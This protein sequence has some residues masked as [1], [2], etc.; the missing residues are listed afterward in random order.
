MY[1]VICAKY[2]DYNDCTA[3]IVQYMYP[4]AIK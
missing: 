1:S 4:K 2:A 3:P